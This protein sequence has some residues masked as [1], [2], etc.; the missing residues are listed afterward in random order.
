M[1]MNARSEVGSPFEVLA[2]SAPRAEP[3]LVAPLIPQSRSARAKIDLQTGE[4]ESSRG[5]TW[6]KVG[7][8]TLGLLRVLFRAGGGANGGDGLTLDEL[9]HQLYG[10]ESSQEAA[11]AHRRIHTLIGR[12]RLWARTQDLDLNIQVNQGGV[13]LLWD[14]FRVEFLPERGLGTPQLS[15]QV[16]TT[17]KLL[18]TAFEPGQWVGSADVAQVLK[19]SIRTSNYRL[20]ALCES[21]LLTASGKG[22]ARRYRFNHA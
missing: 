10:R 11:S 13:R 20:K 9:I 1:T 2:E 12:V 4:V 7:D 14:H 17:E 15:G 18:R 21:G 3:R 19:V 16:T 8:L 5:P 6:L 22:P